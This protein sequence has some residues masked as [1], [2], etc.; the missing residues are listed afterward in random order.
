MFHVIRDSEGMINTISR[1]PQSGSEV[2][3][4]LHPEIRAFLGVPGDAPAF[5][6]MDADF[7]R[8]IEDLIDTLIKNNVIRLTDL[9]VVAQTKL[10]R[11]K[12][13]RNKLGGALD[14]LGGEDLVL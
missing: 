12:G 13:M 10:M 9:P 2:L 1:H 4:D 6:E 7:V 5:T 11:R 3:D 8:V 14:L